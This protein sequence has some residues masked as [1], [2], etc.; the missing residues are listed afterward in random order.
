MQ[1]FQT[2]KAQIDFVPPKTEK[3]PVVDELHGY[4]L[5]DNYQWLEDK[6]DQKVIDWTRSQHDYTLQYL[7][8]SSKDIDGLEGEIA[9]YI[10]RDITGP[11]FLAGERQFF[12]VKKKGEQQYK[13][14]H[15]IRR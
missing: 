14:V 3:K 10:D 13:T 6:T 12:Y 8:A 4:K 1:T 5:T 15:P 9:A 7:K 11:I 2:T